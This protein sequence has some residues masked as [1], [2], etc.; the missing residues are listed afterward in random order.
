MY[1][2]RDVPGLCLESNMSKWFVLCNQDCIWLRLILQ[3]IAL[4]LH[5]TS[6]KD[7]LSDAGV[8]TTAAFCLTTIA[9][10]EGQLGA[11]HTLMP[12]D[13]NSSVM[14]LARVVIVAPTSME[15]RVYFLVPVRFQ[16]A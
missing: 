3:H 16:L 13:C 4:G 15:S 11:Q 6:S 2:E 8:S 5:S 9:M 12:A 10:S 7:W 14:L 1:L